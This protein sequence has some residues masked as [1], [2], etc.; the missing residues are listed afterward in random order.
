MLT[1]HPGPLSNPVNPR[2]S[3]FQRK[4]FLL[5]AAAK[6]RLSFEI[7]KKSKHFFLFLHIHNVV[8]STKSKVNKKI[9]VHKFVDHNFVYQRFFRTYTRNLVKI[10][11]ST[12]RINVNSFN[13]AEEFYIFLPLHSKFRQQCNPNF[14]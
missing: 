4:A 3:A 14:G 1:H 13:Y 7:C 12:E 11:S 8:P 2:N 6:V 5:F 9:E 10:F